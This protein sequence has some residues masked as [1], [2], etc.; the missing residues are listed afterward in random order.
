MLILTY[1]MAVCFQEMSMSAPWRWRDNNSK[2]VGAMYQIVR[3]HY[4]ILRLLVLH[5]Y[6]TY[7]PQ[8]TSYLQFGTNMT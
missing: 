7:F 2:H 6:F 4:N 8:F 3:I 1:I 5:K